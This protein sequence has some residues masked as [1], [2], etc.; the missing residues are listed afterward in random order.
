M[1]HPTDPD[2]TGAGAPADQADLETLL[3]ER[4]HLLNVAFRMLGTRADAEDVVQETYA[5]WFRLTDAEREA[6][7]VPGA[8]LTRVASRLCLDQ[9]GSARAR[10]ESYVGEWLPEPLPSAALASSSVAEDPL[11]RITLDD[12]VTMALLV[13][14]DSLTP[15]ERV[16]FVLHD[17]FAL[18]FDEIAAIVGRTP[19]ACRKL[20]SSART[21][22]RDRR[23]GATTP[24]YHRSVVEAFAAACQGGDIDAL[25][26]LLDPTV[27]ARSDG[28]GRVRA[29][30]NPIVGA[31][32][33]A[34]F[35]LGLIA[36]EDPGRVTASFEEVNGL[37]GIVFRRS[38]TVAVV[39]SLDV[40]HDRVTDVW[41]VLNPDKLTAWA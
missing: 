31:D 32:R 23:E 21:H 30:I 37:T 36:K 4:Q 34:R 35:L 18:P 7:E 41:M 22:I 11:D 16:A 26:A 9:L 25:L 5:R 29:A 8:W 27:T 6:I 39:L 40:R 2:R 1:T 14:L 12:S 20:A 13:V 33:V 3:G 19:Q 24:E 28:G 17:V 38:G 15:A 10:R